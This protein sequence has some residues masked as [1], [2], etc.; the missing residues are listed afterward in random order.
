MKIRRTNHFSFYGRANGLAGVAF[1]ALALALIL[2]GCDGSAESGDGTKSPNAT[3]PTSPPAAPPASAEGDEAPGKTTPSAAGRFASPAEIANEP[4]EA[5]E[6]MTVRAFDVRGM[7]CSGC[8]N[9]IGEAV[10][11]L[12][13]VEKVRVSLAHDKAWVRSPREAGPDDPMIINAITKAGYE[14]WVEGE[15]P[16][17]SSPSE[18]A[19]NDDESDGSGDG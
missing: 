18:N 13:G 9:S 15:A 16:P 7:S 2:P 14:A 12:P 19:D 10:A 5:R 17:P 8:A 1:A 3:N 4:L 6:G 11:S